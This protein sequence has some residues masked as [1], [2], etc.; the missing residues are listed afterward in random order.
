MKPQNSRCSTTSP[1]LKKLRVFSINCL[2]ERLAVDRRTLKRALADTPHTMRGRF[3]CYALADARAALAAHR[4]KMDPLESLRADLLEKRVELLGE[5]LNEMRADLI[6]VST[7]RE[8]L[9]GFQQRI[10]AALNEVLV[11]QY[12]IAASYHEPAEL[13]VIGKRTVDELCERLQR[14]VDPWRK[15]I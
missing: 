15:A 12:P 6:R 14:A 8:M 3:R 5:K 13:R 10:I 1:K 4:N 11:E 7:V 9:A 2:S